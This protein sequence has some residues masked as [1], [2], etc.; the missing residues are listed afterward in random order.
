MCWVICLETR[1][2]HRASCPCTYDWSGTLDELSLQ[3]SVV[4]NELKDDVQGAEPL[5]VPAGRIR[6]E[7][8]GSRMAAHTMARRRATVIAFIAGFAAAP[9]DPCH[10][11]T[12]HQLK[13]VR[14][15][16]KA[17]SLVGIRVASLASPCIRCVPFHARIRGVA[18]S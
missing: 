9:L 8:V 4:G 16:A 11:C 5:S 2:E 6:A 17:T 7:L 18:G 15:L 14:Q 1:W 3:H 10:V 13:V 12:A